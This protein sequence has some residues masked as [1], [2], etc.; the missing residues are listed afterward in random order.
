M[1]LRPL[2]IVVLFQ[3]EDRLYK[4]KSDV[5]RR[6]SLT[7]KDG[8]RAEKVKEVTNHSDKRRITFII[9]QEGSKIVLSNKM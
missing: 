3:R 8:P 9:C 6:P 7:Y 4:S 1:A 2:W 5:N